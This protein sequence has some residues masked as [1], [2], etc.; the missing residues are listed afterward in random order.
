MEAIGSPS[1]EYMLCSSA[2]RLALSKGLHR[3]PSIQW[4]LSEVETLQRSLLFWSVY[5][6]DRQISSRSGRPPVSST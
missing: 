1:L 4:G 2:A 5:C 6:Y 3:K